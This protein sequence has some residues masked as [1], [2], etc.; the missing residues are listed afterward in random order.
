MLVL[1]IDPGKEG[2][3][4]LIHDRELVAVFDMPVLKLNKGT[5][6]CGHTLNAKLADILH[7]YPPIDLAVIENV[8]STPQ[9][10][11]ASSFDFGRSFGVA[12]MAIIARGIRLEYTRPAKWKGAL[13]LNADKS[14]SLA[15]ARATWPSSDAFTL[16]KH[17]GRAEAALIA[18]YGRRFAD[19]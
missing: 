5:K 6:V 11:V 17:E 19:G 7:P 3:V 2:A 8:H 13:G 1:G 4:A 15:L 10:G 16:K 14:S 12:E 9:M 18:E